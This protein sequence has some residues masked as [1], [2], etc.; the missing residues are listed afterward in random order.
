LGPP[1]FEEDQYQYSVITDRFKFTLFVL[2]R[3]VTE[4]K[5]KYDK[6]VVAK[7]E[8]EGFTR[9]YNKPTETFQGK[10]CLYTESDSE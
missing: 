1:T 2:A 3:N 10:E 5:Q 6:E 7:L 4:F 9:F 8:E